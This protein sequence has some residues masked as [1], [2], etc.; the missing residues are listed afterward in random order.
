MAIVPSENCGTVVT[1]TINSG[2]RGTVRELYF[3]TGEGIR[4]GGAYLGCYRCAR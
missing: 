3:E 1:T 2:R 4:T